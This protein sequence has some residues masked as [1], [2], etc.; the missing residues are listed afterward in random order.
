MFSLLVER[1]LTCSS[2]STDYGFEVLE[3]ACFWVETP[4]P[5]YYTDSLEDCIKTCEQHSCLQTQFK[6]PRC[7]MVTPTRYHFAF[8]SSFVLRP[9]NT[10]SFSI[11]R[12][13]INGKRCYIFPCSLLLKFVSDIKLFQLQEAVN[14]SHARSHT[15]AHTRKH[16]RTHNLFNLST[17]LCILVLNVCTF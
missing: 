16:A 14:H 4:D 17:V 8:S 7:T 9:R 5:G 2:S 1:D 11:T 10:V 3:R 12:L 6:C 15:R 13:C